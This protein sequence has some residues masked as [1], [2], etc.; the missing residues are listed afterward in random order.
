[1]GV[2]AEENM[3]CAG[4]SEE[5]DSQYSEQAV[6]VKDNTAAA[7]GPKIEV[8]QGPAL[9]PPTG[10]E[11]H[12]LVGDNIK[13]VTH[14][15]ET[16][17]VKDVTK[18]VDWKLATASSLPGDQTIEDLKVQGVSSPF[19]LE[20][21]LIFHPDDQVCELDGWEEG[22]RFLLVWTPKWDI[23][24]YAEIIDHLKDEGNTYWPALVQTQAGLVVEWNTDLRD[25]DIPTKFGGS[26]A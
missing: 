18:F 26:K 24:K 12:I 5:G 1:M 2:I 17:T 15:A 16:A 4:S 8:E 7:E 23:T 9:P 21:G 25:S 19:V 6:K 20:D 11:T 13:L 22:E 10:A 3:G 14:L